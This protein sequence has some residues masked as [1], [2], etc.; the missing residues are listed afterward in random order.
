MAYPSTASGYNMFDMLS[1]MQKAIRRGDYHHAGFAANQLKTTYRTAMWNRLFVISAEDCFG[2]VTKELVELRKMD[3]KRSADS[4][5]S[6]AIALLCKSKKSRDACYFSCNFVLSSRSPRTLDVGY[7]DVCRFI[8]FGFSCTKKQYDQFGFQQM[9][10]FDDPSDM[11]EDETEECYD[12]ARIGA[13]LQLAL[14]HR[15]MDMIG[16]AMDQLRRDAR[17]FLW[18]V[19]EDYALET[20]VRDEVRALKQADDTVNRNKAEKDEIFIS[21]AAI[22]LCYVKDARF[23][24]VASSEFVVFDHCMDWQKIKVMPITECRLKDGKIPDWVYDCHTLKGKKMGKTDWDMTVTEQ[25]ALFPLQKAY[26]D[27]ASWLY[28]YEQDLENGVLNEDGMRPIWEYAE[29]HPVNPIE[30]IPYDGE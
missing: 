16:Y 22:L 17:D 14:R 18:Y 29:N 6:N 20:D 1:M 11:N 12:M 7:D 24:T 8:N 4:N 21:K 23:Q 26:F 5:I 13:G 2:V 19:F 15:D 28:T 3:E 9:S 30:H 25:A 10:L 27:E